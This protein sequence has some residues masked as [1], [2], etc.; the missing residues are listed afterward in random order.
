V[1]GSASVGVVGAGI[2][3]L[4]TAYALRE[5]GAD[6]RVYERGVPG[7]G[8]S[9]GDSRIFRHAHGDRRLIEFA[10]AGREIWSEWAERL[11][12]E[13]VSPDGVVAIGDAVKDR[14]KLL[15]QTAEID[16]RAID[17][18]ELRERLPLLADYDGPAMYD[19]AGGAIRAREAIGALAAELGDSL[20]ADEVI[21]LTAGGE[22]GGVE[23]RCGGVSFTHERLVV[24]AGRGTA[25]LAHGVGITLPVKLGA[26]VRG[27]YEVRGDPP[28]Q[29]ACLQDSSGRFG[30][31]GVYAAPVAGNRRY[32]LGLSQAVDA[33]G[34][35]SLVDPGGLASLAERASAYVE[36][37]LPGL[38]PEPVELRH[39]WVTELP[40]GS[41]GVA[42][43][44]SNGIFFVAG[45]NLFKQAPGLGR[46]LARAALGQALPDELRPA[47]ELG[48]A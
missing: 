4:S 26:H 11:G 23:V 7:N 25:P 15:E 34:D 27:T 28:P 47:A 2:V 24:C 29:L 16:A 14:L 10:R 19:E 45:H 6:V 20:V 40:W 31:V 46:A 22:A 1:A 8:Q 13:L 5:Q 21:S 39:C 32:A 36:K 17:A 42:V 35:G 44:E 12:I 43:W 3:G 38:V 48:R 18:S 9:G 41:D 30:E 37:A 33:R